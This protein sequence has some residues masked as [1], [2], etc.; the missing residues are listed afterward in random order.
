MKTVPYKDEKE[1]KDHAINFIKL[2]SLAKEQYE[3]RTTEKKV[4]IFAST[5]V[6]AF[7]AVMSLQSVIDKSQKKVQSKMFLRPSVLRDRPFRPPRTHFSLYFT[8][9]NP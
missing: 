1:T 3:I 7:Y 8:C 2:S 5:S 4:Q 9:V 6:G